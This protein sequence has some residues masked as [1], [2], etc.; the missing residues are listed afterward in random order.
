M[1]CL[2][3][4][5]DSLARMPGG[6]A[7]QVLQFMEGS[8]IIVMTVEIEDDDGTYYGEFILKF[9]QC[10]Y[11]PHLFDSCLLYAEERHAV[12]YLASQYMPAYPSK[13]GAIVDNDRRI[14]VRM[15]GPEDRLTK[16]GA[17]AVFTDLF[18]MARRV[19]IT[20]VWRL[21]ARA[22]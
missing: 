8:F 11:S 17:R 12:A 15:L 3:L 22:S 16:A 19:N 10:M 2:T 5:K 6:T 9:E 20:S 18:P 13:H 1:E 4:G 21:S 7:F 14:G